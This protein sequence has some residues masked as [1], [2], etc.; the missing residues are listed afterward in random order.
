MAETVVDDLEAVEVQEQD[1][2]RSV[3][4]SGSGEGM[5]EQLVEQD[6]VGQLGQGIVMSLVGQLVLEDVVLDR[7]RGQLQQ[8]F[9]GRLLGRGRASRLAEIGPERPEDPPVGG[10]PY[11]CRPAAADLLGT[12]EVTERLGLRVV[13]HVGDD[14]GLGPKRRGPA[15]GGTLGD[16][17]VVESPGERLG[18][19]RCGTEAQ[20]HGIF[21]DEPDRAPHVSRGGLHRP[22]DLREDVFDRFA[23]GDHL[24]D[25]RLVAQSSLAGSQRLFGLSLDRD[26]ASR[27]DDPVD[28]G[29]VDQ[30]V[31]DGLH[32][33]PVAVGVA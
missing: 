24:Q 26:V 19:R 14:D 25:V 15:R 13:E 30:V 6:S 31:A 17:H 29:V 21:V 5:F 7:D 9:D 22:A 2:D 16:G 3:G 33:D 27:D 12:G 32:R 8:R 1:R 20:H 23:G 28:A 4:P 18:E 11:W 10:G